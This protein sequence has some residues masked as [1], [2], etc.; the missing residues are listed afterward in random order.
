MVKQLL[1]KYKRSEFLI[2]VSSGH[3]KEDPGAYCDATE[4]YEYSYVEELSFKLQELLRE[5]GYKVY[6]PDPVSDELSYPDHLKRSVDLL[7]LHEVDVALEIHLNSWSTPNASGAEVLANEKGVELATLVQEEI[8]KM[9]FRDRG[10]KQPKNKY[11][12]NKVEGPAI[13]TEPGFISSEKDVA[14]I[15][16]EGF[17]NEFC[18]SVAFALDRYHG[19]V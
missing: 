13:I 3:S 19:I 6:S 9:G 4:K 17:Q 2:G 11:F 5:L 12:L 15:I 1:K 16:K 14:I 18:V 8:V 10:V 7:N